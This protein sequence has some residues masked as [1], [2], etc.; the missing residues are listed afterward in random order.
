[1]LLF[2]NPVPSMFLSPQMIEKKNEG[3]WG[4]CILKPDP[5]KMTVQDCPCRTLLQKPISLHVGVESVCATSEPLIRSFCKRDLSS[6]VIY[7]ASAI[8]GLQLMGALRL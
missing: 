7:A 6:L 8:N 4:S 1:M 2:A 3:M 5:T